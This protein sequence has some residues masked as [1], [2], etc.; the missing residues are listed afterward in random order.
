M[1]ISR[2]QTPSQLSMSVAGSRDLSLNSRHEVSHVRSAVTIYRDVMPRIEV[3]D[4][5]LLVAIGRAAFTD[6]PLQPFVLAKLCFGS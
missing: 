1:S 3:S 6:G 5:R 4:Q 2:R